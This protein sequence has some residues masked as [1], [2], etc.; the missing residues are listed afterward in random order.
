[1]AVHVVLLA[2]GRGTRFWPMSRRRRPKQFLPL[3]SGES[4]LRE[5]WQ[6]VRVL[7]KPERTWVITAAD[8][9]RTCL[10]ELPELPPE[11]CIGEPVGR[12]TAP[13][14]ALAT[15]LIAERDP[16]AVLGIF[17]SD[18]YIGD[19]AAFRRLARAALRTAR[20][21]RALVTLGIKPD[22]AETGYGYIK[23]EP[24]A[25]EGTVSSVL[26]FVEKPTLARARRFVSGGN[27]LW[28]SGMFFLSVPA[29]IEAWREHAPEIYEPLAELAPAFGGRGFTKRLKAVY[30]RLPSQPFDVAIMEK[31]ADVRVLPAE[32]GWNDLG[33]WLAL[34]EL[35]PE[36]GENRGTGPLVCSEARGNIVMDPEG[37]TALIGVDD[38]VIVRS[39]DILLV[40]HRDKVQDLREMVERLE[41]EGLS[42]YV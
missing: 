21:E 19:L 17:P 13:A 23:C 3:A 37:L 5:T 28:N 7:A 8:L 27:Y 25:S 29:L 26:G 20:E 18:H 14:M 38:L 15:A 16:R 4:L 12:N 6:R 35:I 34:A 39:G 36:R 10:Q 41:S 33:H 30:E 22:R 1:M 40:C 42:R 24:G 32:M 11:Q 31:A 2:G 9:R